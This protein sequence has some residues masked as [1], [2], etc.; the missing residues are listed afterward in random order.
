MINTVQVNEFPF[1]G[2]EGLKAESLKEGL[3]SLC[4]VE[5]DWNSNF[6][7]FDRVGEGL[8]LLKKGGHIIGFGA[9]RQTP[10]APPTAGI[11]RLSSLY[12]KKAERG[13]GYGSQL[14]SDILKYAALTHG[15]IE[16]K[17]DLAISFFEKNGFEKISGNANISHQIDL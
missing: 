16:L 9:I 17:A 1:D 13:K 8:F 12:I 3:N 10:F 2:F 14:L 6:C 5:R 4:N 11:G 7:R 15:L